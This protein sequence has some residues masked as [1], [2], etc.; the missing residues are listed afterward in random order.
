MIRLEN[1]ELQPSTNNL[2]IKVS[3]FTKH[4]RV[5]V[6]A[7]QFMANNSDSLSSLMEQSFE[8]KLMVTNFPFA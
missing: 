5:H 3:N 8:E 4:S 6:Y 1:I 2:D 7:T